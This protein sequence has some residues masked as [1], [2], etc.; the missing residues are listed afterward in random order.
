VLNAVNDALTGTGVSFDHIPVLPGE[1]CAA[2]A[3]V[4]GEGAAAGVPAGAGVT[5][6]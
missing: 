5:E 3:S 6:E 4:T 2:L 1:V